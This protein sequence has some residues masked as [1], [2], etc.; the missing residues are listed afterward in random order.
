MSVLLAF[1][2]IVGAATLDTVVTFALRGRLRYWR[3]RL[4][5]ARRRSSLAQWR[6]YEVRAEGWLLDAWLDVLKD[7]TDV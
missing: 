3:L 5:R 6:L 7:G 2:A 1:L 4:I